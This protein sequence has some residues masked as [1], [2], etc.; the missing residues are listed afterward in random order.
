METSTLHELQM[1]K[2][3]IKHNLSYTGLVVL[4]ILLSLPI[5][6][7]IIIRDSKDEEEEEKK[8]DVYISLNCTKNDESISSTFLNDIPQSMMYKVK[9]NQVNKNTP[10]ESSDNVTSNEVQSTNSPNNITTFGDDQSILD[11]L[12]KIS[13]LKYDSSDNT[14]YIKLSYSYIKSIPGY[15][16]AFGTIKDQEKLFTSRGFTCTQTQF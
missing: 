8:M 7:R 16:T 3:R 15:E 1:K 6:L 12:S 9:G 14:S 5:A 2:K 11:I 13:D 4:T 10:D